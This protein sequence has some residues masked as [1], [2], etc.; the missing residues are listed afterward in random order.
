VTRLKGFLRIQAGIY[1]AFAIGWFFAPAFVNDSMLGWDT[2]TFFPRVMG[3][4]FFG[5]AWGAWKTA[6]K[7]A[8]RMDLVWMFAAVP[9]GYFA[10][11]VWEG[12][13]GDYSG[14]GLFW[15]VCG[16]ITAISGLGVLM[17][18][19]L[20]EREPAMPAQRVRERELVG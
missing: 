3:G 16:A 12:I 9:L 8:E 19:M 7:L 13:S 20:A 4:G 15:W 14:S 11:M 17:L 1:L 5:L 10:A 2:E 18:R 6:E